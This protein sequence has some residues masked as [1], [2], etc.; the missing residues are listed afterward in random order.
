MLSLILR[1]LDQQFRTPKDTELLASLLYSLSRL[2]RFSI[3]SMFI[4]SRDKKGNVKTMK[5]T[6]AVIWSDAKRLGSCAQRNCKRGIRINIR[7]YDS[8][9]SKNQD[10][11]MSSRREMSKTCVVR[12]IANIYSYS[13]IV[14]RTS[15]SRIQLIQS[16]WVRLQ[17][18]INLI[19]S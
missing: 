12:E 11:M 8:T 5:W 16:S 6:L 1:C 17:V 14:R 13:S 2:S 4:D 9:K 7:Y 3:V 18:L 10:F 15:F 19:N